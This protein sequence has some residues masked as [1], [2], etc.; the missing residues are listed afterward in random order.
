M[1]LMNC[2]L[3]TLQIFGIYVMVNQRLKRIKLYKT[4]RQ[5]W[6]PDP[7]NRRKKINKNTR[8]ML[9]FNGSKDIEA[10]HRRPETVTNHIQKISQNTRSFALKVSD[11]TCYDQAILSRF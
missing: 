11:L 2:N 5:K 4:A 6:N 7:T 3:N 10:N 9:S 8:L 1:T